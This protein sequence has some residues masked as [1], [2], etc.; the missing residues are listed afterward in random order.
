MLTDPRSRPTQLSA[1]AIICLAAGAL[2]LLS[3][4]SLV[5]VGGVLGM[6]GVQIGSTKDPLI[7]FLFGIVT[8]AL[9]GA[10]LALYNGFWTVRPWAFTGGFLVAGAGMVT[11]L[12]GLLFGYGDIGWALTNFVVGVAVM[13]ILLMPSSQQALGRPVGDDDGRRRSRPAPLRAV[14]G[15][16][17][18]AEPHD[19]TAADAP[20]PTPRQR[21]RQ[22]PRPRLK[23]SA[24]GGT[25]SSAESVPD[26]PAPGT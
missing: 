5:V 25:E 26:P 10:Y 20:A 19:R 2:L 8:L 22:H 11:V 23:S 6:N 7:A 14:D 17:A 13:G 21:S 16:L 9:A 4:F 18:E 1:L 24:I 12:A 3:G 15:D